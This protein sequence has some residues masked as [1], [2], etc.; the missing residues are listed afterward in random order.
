MTDQQLPQA[1]GGGRG[2]R[3][4]SGLTGVARVLNVGT[5]SGMP[6]STSTRRQPSCS[7]PETSLMLGAIQ[8]EQTTG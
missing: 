8:A 7:R 1:G 2:S 5:V 3:E 4:A 6:E